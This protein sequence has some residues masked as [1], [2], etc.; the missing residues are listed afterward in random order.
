MTDD[1]RAN[2]NGWNADIPPEHRAWDSDADVGAD[3]FGGGS[4]R[5]GDPVE[6]AR[7]WGSNPGGRRR[8]GRP[9]DCGGERGSPDP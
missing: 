7:K 9:S 2:T 3:H 6:L 8:P 1:Q 4:F 5:G